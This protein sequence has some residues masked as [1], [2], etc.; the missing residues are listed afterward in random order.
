MIELLQKKNKGSII[1]NKLIINVKIS[2]KFLEF[3]LLLCIINKKI[4]IIK[5]GGK[6]YGDK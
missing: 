5:I 3:Y 2:N 6:L 1:N 4:K